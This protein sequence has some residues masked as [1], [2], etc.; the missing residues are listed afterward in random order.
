MGFSMSC[1][2]FGDMTKHSPVA[3]NRP[4]QDHG[5]GPAVLP[6]GWWRKKVP[7]SGWDHE[8]GC[9]FEVDWGYLGRLTEQH[10]RLII[11]ASFFPIWTRMNKVV[12]LSWSI[13]RCMP[14]TNACDG[15]GFVGLYQL[16]NGTATIPVRVHFH[17]IFV[18]FHPTYNRANVTQ[19]NIKFETKSTYPMTSRNTNKAFVLKRLGWVGAPSGIPSKQP[20]GFVTRAKLFE[21]LRRWTCSSGRWTWVKGAPGAQHVKIF[22]AYATLL[23]VVYI[24]WYYSMMYHGLSTMFFQNDNA[25]HCLLVMTLEAISVH[26]HWQSLAQ[27]LNWCTGFPSAVGSATR[28]I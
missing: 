19:T 27:C 10:L 13:N 12:V 21:I 26:Q 22:A 15:G 4:L 16:G 9:H 1:H 20:R 17:W 7:S 28:F 11:Y 3:L 5:A 6:S 23:G 18:D 8:P 25:S 24:M 14:T 2:S